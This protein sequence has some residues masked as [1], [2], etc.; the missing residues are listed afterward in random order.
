MI[1]KF[2]KKPKK[3][4]NWGWKTA[5]YFDLW[6]VQHFMAG[7]SY[8]FFLIYLGVNTLWAWIIVVLLGF[9]WELFE[10]SIR[11]KEGFLIGELGDI[12]YSSLG[13]AIV[14]HFVSI[15]HKLNLYAGIIVIVTLVA[16]GYYSWALWIKKYHTT[17]LKNKF[18]KKLF[19]N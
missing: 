12:F 5:T 1:I 8:G 18:S 9:G 16:W 4:F 2:G 10:D 17:G 14:F 11:M 13:F 7:I 6:S 19:N 3:N 15:P